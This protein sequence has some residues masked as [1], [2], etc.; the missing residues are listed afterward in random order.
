MGDLDI[1]KTADSY[2]VRL[3]LDDTPEQPYDDGAVPVLQLDFQPYGSLAVK[4]FNSQAEPYLEAFLRIMAAAPSGRAA[5]ERFERYA[6]VFLGTVKVQQYNIGHF[7]KYAY[8]A[9]DTAAWAADMQV[10]AEQLQAEDY[11]SEIRAWAEGDCWGWIVEK[12]RHWTK[13]YSDGETEQG[14]SWEQVES[15]WG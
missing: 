6:R 8:L 4:A 12:Q 11:L 5:V 7:D 9:F 2:R 15:C 1:I 14:S 10:S 13:T 3:E